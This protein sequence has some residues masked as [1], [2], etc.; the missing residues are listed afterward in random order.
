MSDYAI[1]DARTGEYVAS[2]IEWDGR[3]DVYTDPDGALMWGTARD[4]AKA[5]EEYELD[6]RY[7]V[8][9]L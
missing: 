3:I 9:R 2:V 6:D 5:H 4:A 1:R 7:E 8:V